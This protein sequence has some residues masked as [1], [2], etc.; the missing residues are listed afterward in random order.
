MLK[1]G[2]KTLGAFAVCTAVVDGFVVRF[3]AALGAVLAAEAGVVVGTVVVVVVVV[4]GAVVAGD[5]YSI[6]IPS[7]LDVRESLDVCGVR[8]GLADPA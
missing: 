4:V 7:E 5:V 8:A 2:A 3:E 6:S 1:I